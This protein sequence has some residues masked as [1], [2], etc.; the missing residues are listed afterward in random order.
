VTRS[1]G[2]RGAV[3]GGRLVGRAPGRL[4]HHIEAEACVCYLLPHCLAASICTHPIGRTNPRADGVC[5]IREASQKLKTPWPES[6][7]EL[8]RPSDRR[9]CGLVVPGYITEMY[10]ASCEV[11]TEVIYV[12]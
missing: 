7:S 12:M 8:F 2:F 11:R 9:L 4:L 10:C 6:A 1:V 5:I 3:Y